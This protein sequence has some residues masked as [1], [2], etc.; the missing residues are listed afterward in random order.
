MILIVL[1]H[2][3]SIPAAG[4]LKP[5]DKAFPIASCRCLIVEHANDKINFYVGLV[6][7]ISIKVKVLQQDERQK[8]WQ[9]A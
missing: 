5:F 2:I 4:M 6:G 3:D 1:G 9:G 8:A 7:M